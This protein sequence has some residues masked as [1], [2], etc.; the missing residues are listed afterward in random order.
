MLFLNIFTTLT[1]FLLGNRTRI[2]RI[3]G[4]CFCDRKGTVN[5]L[6][7]HFLGIRCEQQQHKN[8]GPSEIFNK[9]RKGKRISGNH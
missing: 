3:W 1:M 4:F 5:S 2:E 6:Q 7:G 9:N 8:D